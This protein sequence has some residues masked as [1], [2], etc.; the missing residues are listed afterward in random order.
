MPDLCRQVG[1]LMPDKQ[2]GQAQRPDP[3]G[4]D[5]ASP[6][7]EPGLTN[8]P[9]VFKRYASDPAVWAIS[10]PDVTRALQ[11]VKG[12]DLRQGGIH[13]HGRV[14]AY[15]ANN[16]PNMWP[17]EIE[18]ANRLGIRRETVHIIIKNLIEVGL[19]KVIG[20][21][22]RGV[23][24]FG[25]PMWEHTYELTPVSEPVPTP[26]H[27]RVPT[28]VPEPVWANT[29]KQNT[30]DN[31]TEHVPG[32]YQ[33][34]MKDL[35][36]NLVPDPTDKVNELFMS[37]LTC[38]PEWKDRPHEY[39]QALLRMSRGITSPGGM[40]KVMHKLAAELES[41]QSEQGQQLQGCDC[42]MHPK[43]TGKT[44]EDTDNYMKPKL[45]PCVHMP[46]A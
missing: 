35:A 3:I 32:L 33:L 44:Y 40:V 6:M 2:K 41:A 18:I 14:L 30:T 28:P 13:A 23:K 27:E 15:I 26:D 38:K 46:K 25:L 31:R 22:P 16:Y 24:V 4:V 8:T 42:P 36:S 12:L 9:I 39:G 10:S 43:C 37:A 7:Y 34:A 21:R 5:N 20:H 1:E 19:L 45:C 11:D 29:H 17:S